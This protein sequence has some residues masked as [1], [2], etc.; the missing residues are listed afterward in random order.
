V[1]DVLQKMQN[2]TSTEYLVRMTQRAPCPS[3]QDVCIFCRPKLVWL[4]QELFQWSM[5]NIEAEDE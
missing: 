4:P 3:P 2:T 1:P 5:A